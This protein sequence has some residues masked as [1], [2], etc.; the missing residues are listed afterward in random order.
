[1]KKLYTLAIAAFC[2][3][4][5][6]FGQYDLEVTLVSPTAGSTTAGSSVSEI[7]YSITNNGPNDIP[8]GDTVF[9][10]VLHSQNNY[11]IN[12][13]AGSAT[14]IVLP[15]ALTS[16]TT[17]QS[18][19]IG[20]NATLD[21]TGV[22]GQ[23]CMYIT[24]GEQSFLNG[25]DPDDTNMDNNTSCFTADPSL[26]GVEELEF[27]EAVE[28]TFNSE[29][30]NISS[31]LNKEL[32]YSV[33]SITGQEVAN[34]SVKNFTSVSTEGWNRGIYIVRVE[35]SNEVTTTKIIVQ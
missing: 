23:V 8:Q 34:G 10:A 25:N 13:T 11:S 15:S 14:T 32:N 16:G 12:G 19:Q 3:T 4:T 29:E 35:G 31:E 33:V 20:A 21:L 6:S 7:E 22:D 9:I 17:L 18:S 1:M 26:A 2:F 24:V 27:A 5:F 30:I 28:V